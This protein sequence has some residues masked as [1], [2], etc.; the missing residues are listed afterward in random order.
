MNDAAIYAGKSQDVIIRD[1]LTYGNVIGIELENTVNGEVYNNVAHDNTV[2][3]FIDLLPQ[4]P[5]KV[6][7]NTKV[8]DNVSEN[9][10]GENFG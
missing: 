2:G 3:I 1:T 9:N 4:L 5:S 8:H 7:L 10:N 6:S